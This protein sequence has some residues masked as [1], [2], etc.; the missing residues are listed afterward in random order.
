RPSHR[1]RQPE[2]GAVRIPAARRLRS[3]GAQR[4]KR[5]D[6]RYRAA[7]AGIE[8][9]DRA[10]SAGIPVDAGYRAQHEFHLHDAAPDGAGLCAPL[11]AQDAEDADRAAAAAGLSRLEQING[12]R[13]RARVAAQVLLR[14]L[15]AALRPRGRIVE[16]HWSSAALQEGW[17]R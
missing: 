6:R 12:C 10:A 14:D 11:R 17:L 2:P 4:H 1:W 16:A 3:T 8:A 9:Q 15:S 7:A 13:S 5:L